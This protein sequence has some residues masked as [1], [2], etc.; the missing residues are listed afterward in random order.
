MSN[1]EHNL[2]AE[3]KFKPYIEALLQGKNVQ[4]RHP[5][6][7]IW[8]DLD[9][10]TLVVNGLLNYQFRFKPSYKELSDELFKKYNLIICKMSYI[11]YSDALSKHVT[12][13]DVRFKSD[14]YIIPLNP[15][16]LDPIET[17]EDYHKIPEN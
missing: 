5:T 15:Y 14:K 13:A 1:L 10:Y 2:I 9:L 8:N 6:S 4:F 17:I 7:N 12:F 11:S 16:T 3:T